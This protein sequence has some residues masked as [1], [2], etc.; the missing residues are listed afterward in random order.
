MSGQ[1]ALLAKGQQRVQGVKLARRRA[2]EL[3]FP[4]II[5]GKRRNSRHDERLT[6]PRRIHDQPSKA[7]AGIFN[8]GCGAVF[9]VTAAAGAGRRR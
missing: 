2:D 7:H 3:D 6:G 9:C 4:R 5:S 8:S 1:I